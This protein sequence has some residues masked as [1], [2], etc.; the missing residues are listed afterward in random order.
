MNVYHIYESNVILRSFLIIHVRNFNYV[1][2]T[3]PCLH[4]PRM[5]EMLI[6]EPH[7]VVLQFCGYCRRIHTRCKDS[8]MN[9]LYSRLRC[10]RL[11]SMKKQKVVV[12]AIITEAID[13]MIIRAEKF[14]YM[15][16]EID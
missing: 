14:T 11:F 15:S 1:E 16:A 7:Y 13:K 4:S 9:A 5:V 6:T 8:C 3:I 12:A 10:C 2:T